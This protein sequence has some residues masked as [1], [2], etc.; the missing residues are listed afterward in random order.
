MLFS[1]KTDG[2]KSF[3]LLHTF[4]KKAYY[5][6]GA[7]NLEAKK[8]GGNIKLQCGIMQKLC[9]LNFTHYD[10]GEVLAPGSKARPGHKEDAISF[11]KSGLGGTPLKNSIFEKGVSLRYK[12]LKAIKSKLRR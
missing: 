6:L 12:C 3:A 4:E 9:A 8:H 7:S 5:C 1:L 11:F 2:E 10:V